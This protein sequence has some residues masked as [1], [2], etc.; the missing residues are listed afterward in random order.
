MQPSP[1][2]AQSPSSQQSWLIPSATSWSPAWPGRAVMLQGRPFLG[3]ELVAKRLQL[4]RDVVPGLAR[5]AALWH[6]HAYGEHTMANVVKDMKDIEDAAR[7]LGMQL[8]L[9]SADTE[10]GCQFLA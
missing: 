5:V 10:E 6:P 1:R 7:T 4:L 9:V 8:Q 2:S 3:P